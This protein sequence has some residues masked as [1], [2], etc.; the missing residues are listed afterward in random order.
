MFQ[1]QREV[2]SGLE[3]VRR[4]VASDLQHSTGAVK[5]LSVKF[6]FYII[7]SGRLIKRRMV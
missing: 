5:L 3:G 1:E 6:G 7:E 4:E 2:Q